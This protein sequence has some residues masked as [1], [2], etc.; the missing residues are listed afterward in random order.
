ML[1]LGRSIAAVLLTGSSLHRCVRIN[2]DQASAPSHNVV[3]E[4]TSFMYAG[5]QPPLHACDVLF[6]PCVILYVLVGAQEQ[7][8]AP[9]SR[10]T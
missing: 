6:E 7:V 8:I 3:C 10:L 1:W 9:G 4:L 5:F 2:F